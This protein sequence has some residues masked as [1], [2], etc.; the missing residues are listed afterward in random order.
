MN[1]SSRNVKH[2][3]ACILQKS[4]VSPLVI[5]PVFTTELIVANERILCYNV[6]SEFYRNRLILLFG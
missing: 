5:L 4:S 2:T 1:K 3:Y 6:S